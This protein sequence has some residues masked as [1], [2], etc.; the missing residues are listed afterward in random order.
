[1]LKLLV[2]ILRLKRLK[3]KNLTSIIRLSIG[4]ILRKIVIISILT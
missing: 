4:K 1:M 2:Y 3:T